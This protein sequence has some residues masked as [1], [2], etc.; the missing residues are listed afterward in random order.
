MIK[1]KNDLEDCID[2]FMSDDHLSWIADTYH[3]MIF[4]TLAGDYHDMIVRI[5]AEAEPRHI[6][7]LLMKLNTA[8]IYALKYFGC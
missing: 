8:Y 4:E 2:S 7:E 1:L 6:D 3:N 5:Q